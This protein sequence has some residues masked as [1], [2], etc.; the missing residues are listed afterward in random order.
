MKQIFSGVLL[1]S[2]LGAS[3]ALAD[4]DS[5]RD[6]AC[7]SEQIGVTEAAFRTCFLPVRSDSD[8]D[9]D[10]ATQR[11]NKA[12]L[13]PCLQEANPQLTNAAM[14]ACRPEGPIQN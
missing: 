13:L 6:V 9:P 3:M 4:D 5:N 1:L 12:K 2:A 10:G 7:V 11:A 14:D 8:H